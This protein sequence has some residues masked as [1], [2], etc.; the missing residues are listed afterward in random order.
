VQPVSTSS[1]IWTYRDRTELGSNVSDTHA[2]MTGFSVEALDGSIG[3]VDE[4]TY[5]VGRSHI[6]VDTGPWILG[7][8]VIL[9]AG[10]VRGVDETEELVF[11]N[12]TKDEIKSAPEYDNPTVGDDTYRDLGAYY[13]PDGA[14]HR[15]WDDS[16]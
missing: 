10:I 12:R 3:K 14:G 11:V 5:E 6:V 9:P 8:K 13:G 4:A 1:D 7:K 2:D 16:L 15:S